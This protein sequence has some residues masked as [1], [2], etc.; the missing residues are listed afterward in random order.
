[1]GTDSLDTHAAETLIEALTLAAP[2]GPY[3]FGRVDARDAGAARLVEP[4]RWLQHDAD[5]H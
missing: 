5:T 3:S 2:E 4:E 1:M